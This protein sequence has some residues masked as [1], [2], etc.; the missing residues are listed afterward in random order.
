M[1]RCTER[2]ADRANLSTVWV[3]FS[4]SST[5]AIVAP[6]CTWRLYRRYVSWLSWLH[7]LYLDYKWP[8]LCPRRNKSMTEERAAQ[9][10]IK[11]KSLWLTQDAISLQEV[12]ARAILFFPSLSHCNPRKNGSGSRLKLKCRR[13]WALM[14]ASSTNVEGWK[15][16][17]LHC[18]SYLLE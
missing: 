11:K 1:R 2:C 7:R 14:A 9:C 12:K 6:H 15:C 13:E 4:E 10:W 8:V 3:E 5:C 16:T 18:Q 17:Y